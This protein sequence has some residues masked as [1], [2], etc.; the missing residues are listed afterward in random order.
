[1]ARNWTVDEATEDLA[2]L[3]DAARTSSQYVVV[4]DG[5]FKVSFKKGGAKRL[6]NILDND[7]PLDRDDIEN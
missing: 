2:G 5:S 6:D 4:D 7:G 3:L 1:M